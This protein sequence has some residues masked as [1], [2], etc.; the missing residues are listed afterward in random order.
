MPPLLAIG[1]TGGA[2]GSAD[3][4]AMIDLVFG[5]VEPRPV[6]I[7]SGR[8]SQRRLEPRVIA[9]RQR[10]ERRLACPP[11]LVDVELQ[12][13]TTDLAAPLAPASRPRPTRRFPWL[14]A[15]APRTSRADSRAPPPPRARAASRC[16]C[17]A[18][19]AGDPS[20][21][22][23]NPLTASS[24]VWRVIRKHCHER[25]DR[26]RVARAAAGCDTPAIVSS[27]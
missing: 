19:R 23:V 4:A 15:R 20:R 22:R 24:V 2:R 21:S 14:S 10:R 27:S 8:N 12:L 13:V 1:A 25:P 18:H 3:L 9:R 26:W 7:Q 5:D 16:C 17:F 6:R 11:K